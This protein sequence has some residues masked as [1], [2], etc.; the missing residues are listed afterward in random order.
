ME[1]IQI[2]LLHVSESLVTV[3]IASLSSVF[4]GGFLRV[5]FGSQL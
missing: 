1:F 2:I 3:T 5:A 4:H